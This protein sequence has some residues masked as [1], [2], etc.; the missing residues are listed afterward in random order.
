MRVNNFYEGTLMFITV[1]TLII[2]TYAFF[3]MLLKSPKSMSE[4]GKLLAYVTAWDMLFNIILGFG[5]APGL[6]FPAPGMYFNG[7]A[8][9]IYQ[10]FGYDSA[11]ICLCAWLWV[12]VVLVANQNYCLIYRFTVIRQD[13]R[14]HDF[15]MSIPGIIIMQVIGE[16]I[17]AIIIIPSYHTIIATEERKNELLLFFPEEIYFK[18]PLDS[19]IVMFDTFNT[20]VILI[21]GLV[22]MIDGY[23]FRLQFNTVTNLTVNIICIYLILNHSTK[24][25]GNYKYYILFNVASTMV[26]DF[27]ISGFFGLLVLLPFPITC[28]TGP[29]RYTGH[30]Q[31]NVLNYGVVIMSLSAT[32]LSILIGFLYRYY[33]LRNKADIFH[34]KKAVGI[35][36][37]AVV[38]YPMPALIPI[39]FIL[40]YDKDYANNFVFQK[41]PKFYD[42]YIH[43]TC[44][45]YYDDT[46]PL[47]ANYSYTSYLSLSPIVYVIRSNTGGIRSYILYV[48]IFHRLKTKEVSVWA[49]ILIH[50]FTLHATFNGL[51]IIFSIKPYREALKNWFSKL[52]V[53][54]TINVMHSTTAGNSNNNA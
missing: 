54:D 19:P 48:F 26:M 12:L 18:I 30:Y 32:G 8:Q 37:V 24:A 36:I 21:C 17:C 22:T 7:L 49:E 34:T 33:S 5:I 41:Y 1:I 47:F 44:S 40:R 27:H 43:I 51:L 23:Y 14:Y 3:V 25:M 6:F 53:S 10:A 13:T 28:S 46:L 38:I 42:V 2:Q 15:L 4:Y 50:I 16:S 31:Y 9:D 35:I 29:L 45:A 20:Y 11:R 52:A 39:L